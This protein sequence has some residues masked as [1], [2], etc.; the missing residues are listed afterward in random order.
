MS[1]WGRYEPL[2]STT[3]L[4]IIY[5]QARH[6]LGDTKVIDTLRAL[7]NKGSI[8]W[9]I[10]TLRALRWSASRRGWLVLLRHEICPTVYLCF[11]RCERKRARNQGGCA[12]LFFI[13]LCLVSVEL[14]NLEHSL[15]VVGVIFLCDG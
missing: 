11:T 5:S 8:L 2:A 4:I 13:A 7:R 10:R 9:A 3:D 1:T 12:I 6:P 14:Q 15:G